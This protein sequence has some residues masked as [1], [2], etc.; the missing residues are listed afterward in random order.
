MSMERVVV[1]DFGGQYNQLIARRVRELGVYSEL[2][3]RN[4]EKSRIL[5]DG[6]SGIILTGG[7]DS[8]YDPEAKTCPAYV[9]ELGVPVLGVCYGMQYIAHIFGGQIEAGHREYADTPVEMGTHPLTAGMDAGYVWMNHNDSVTAL[10][11]GFTAIA[12]TAHCVA[13]FANDEKKLYGIQFHAE[14]AHTPKGTLVFENFLKRICRCRC[15]YR[16]ENLAESLIAQIRRQVGGQGRVLGALSG[17]VDS[18]VAAALVHRAVGDRLSC[19]FVDHGLLRQNE[20]EEVRDFYRNHLG[21]NLTAVNAKDRFLQKLA[22]VSEPEQKRKIIGAEFIRVF[23]EESRKLK[24]Q[25]EAWFLL[26]GTIYPDVIESGTDASAKIKSHH[27]V[28][29]LPADMGFAGLVEPLRMLFKDEVRALGESLGIPHDL[30]WRQPFPGPG[31]AIRVLGEVTEEKLS[32]LRHSDA[33]FREE[34]RQAGLQ[35]KIWQ[36][37]TVFTGMRSVGVMG[38]QRTYDYAIGVRAVTSTDAMTVEWAEIPY[39]VLRRIS[40]RII[41]EVPHVNRVVYDIT[42]KPPGTIEWE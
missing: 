42:S 21:L 24:T 19:V 17:G 33:I 34:I 9:F 32:I 10:P 31:L 2:L 37:F 27:N 35:E 6:L 3:P 38:D 30:V 20:A 16:P 23:E 4:A 7:P 11:A 14:V 40:S 8:V 36:Y 18:T 29:G 12:R 1:L 25:N 22:G 28:G 39:P 41:S 26:Q 13:A 5:G 15:D